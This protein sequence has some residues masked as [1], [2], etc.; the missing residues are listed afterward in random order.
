MEIACAL[1]AAHY[2][3]GKCH[4]LVEFRSP[5]APL[6]HS[7][8]RRLWPDKFRSFRL[9]SPRT[10]FGTTGACNNAQPG[11]PCTKK[12]NLVQIDP[13]TGALIKTIGDVDSPEFDFAGLRRVRA[14]MRR[15]PSGGRCSRICRPTCGGARCRCSIGMATPWQHRLCPRP[16]CRHCSRKG[17][18]AAGIEPASESTPSGRPTCLARALCR[19]GADHGHP[20]PGP[21][22]E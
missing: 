17:V 20:A 18:E 3:G 21:F 5:R 15:T 6:A 2:P 1:L 13:Q 12:S 11:R 16:R 4:R 8:P 22:P 7:S 14:S 9:R 19:P 10:L